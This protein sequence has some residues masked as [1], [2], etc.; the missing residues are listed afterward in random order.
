MPYLILYV[1]T[2]S[3]QLI[4]RHSFSIRLYRTLFKGSFIMGFILHMFTD[5]KLDL[6]LCKQA[7]PFLIK[8]ILST[9]PL[10]YRGISL[11]KRVKFHA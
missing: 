4:Q 11:H 5:N 7:Y 6:F 1:D 10:I 9:Q 2:P 3:S 8:K